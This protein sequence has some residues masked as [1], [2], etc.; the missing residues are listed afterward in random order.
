M[1]RNFIFLLN[2]F[3]V[4]KKVKKKKIKRKVK[5]YFILLPIYSSLIKSDFETKGAVL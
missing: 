5:P 3:K 4:R 2:F 1:K